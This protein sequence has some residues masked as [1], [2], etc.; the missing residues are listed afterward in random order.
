M[1]GTSLA[2][3]KLGNE[4]ATTAVRDLQM[5]TT[6]EKDSHQDSIAI[7]RSLFT[8]CAA[9]TTDISSVESSAAQPLYGKCPVGQVEF[10]Y[11]WLRKIPPGRTVE[12]APRIATIPSSS[13]T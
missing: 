10:P 7:L 9:A 11:L 6:L 3:S 5:A 12:F 4:Q 1:L 2:L 8:N 13:R